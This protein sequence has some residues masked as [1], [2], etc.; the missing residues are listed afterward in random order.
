M[1]KSN[2]MS[3]NISHVSKRIYV[4][5]LHIQYIIQMKIQLSVLLTARILVIMV[6]VRMDINVELI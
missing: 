5:H 6:I 4:I 3:M 1:E 2:V